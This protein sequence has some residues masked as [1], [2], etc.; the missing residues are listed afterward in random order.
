MGDSIFHIVEK[1][2]GEIEIVQLVQRFNRSNAKIKKKS[3][4]QNTYLQ[5]NSECKKIKK[6]KQK[7][8][9]KVKKNYLSLTLT[10]KVFPG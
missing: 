6:S 3:Q 10:Y 2:D 9:I 4:L 5:S 1:D 7:S 8:Y